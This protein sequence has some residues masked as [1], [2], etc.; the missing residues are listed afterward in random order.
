MRVG[1]AL[2]VVEA[3]ETTRGD[4]VELAPYAAAG[5]GDGEEVRDSVGPADERVWGQRD[6]VADEFGVVLG[7]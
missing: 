2:E 5:A 1:E 6:V 7:D 3:R 4:G